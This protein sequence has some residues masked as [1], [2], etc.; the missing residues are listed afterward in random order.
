MLKS[1]EIDLID[2]L[3]FPPQEG[4]EKSKALEEQ[5][6]AIDYSNKLMDFLVGKVSEHNKS[7]KN[8]INISQLRNLFIDAFDSCPDENKLSCAIGKVNIFLEIKSLG[9]NKKYYDKNL[10]LKLTDENVMNAKREIDGSS[11]RG[12][13]FS[14]LE[15]LYISEHGPL[16]LDV[17]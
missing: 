9:F 15:D 16:I 6:S 1:F 5:D 2:S 7:C 8:K 14:S 11:L 13:P 12:F 4:Q 17:S 10:S 3:I